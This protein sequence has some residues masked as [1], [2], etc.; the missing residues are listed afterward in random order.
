MAQVYLEVIHQTKTH[1]KIKVIHV[2][3]MVVTTVVRENQQVI[4]SIVV[5]HVQKH[6]HKVLHIT[7]DTII[8]QVD[9]LRMVVEVV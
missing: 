5:Q 9:I 6:L 3:I 2:H 1:I 8:A 4:L 7:V